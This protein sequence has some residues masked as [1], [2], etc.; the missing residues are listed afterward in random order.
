MRAAF[1]FYFKRVDMKSGKSYIVVRAGKRPGCFQTAAGH[2]ATV[3]NPS[4]GPGWESVSI[5]ES[6]ARF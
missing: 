1:S 5:L 3:L 2:T 6:H 4:A